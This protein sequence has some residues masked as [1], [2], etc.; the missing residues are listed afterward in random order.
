MNIDFQDFE[1]VCM[2]R[3]RFLK[4]DFQFQL[5]KVERKPFGIFITY[6]NSSTGVRVSLEPREGRIFVLVCRLIDG[7][8]PE[9]PIFVKPDTPLNCYYLDDIVRLKLDKLPSRPVVKQLL[10]PTGAE[11][12]LTEISSLLREFAADIL[13]GNFTMFADLDRVVKTRAK[14]LT[15]Q[16]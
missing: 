13:T 7:K 8:I 9:Y 5:E 14:E 2:K 10:S 16:E 4:E 12:A 6:L 11:T 15:E 3:L 1:R